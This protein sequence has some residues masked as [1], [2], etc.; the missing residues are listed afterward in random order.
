M[1]GDNVTQMQPSMTADNT[2][3]KK[4]FYDNGIEFKEVRCRFTKEYKPPTPFIRYGVNVNLQGSAGLIGKGTSYY[5][6]S[7][8]MLF[9]SKEEMAQWL[10]YIGSQHKFYDEKGTVYL[11]IVT[12]EPEIEPIQQETKYLVKISLTLVKKQD[13]ERR[14]IHGFIDIDEH[15]AKRYIEEMQS[16]GA[17][18]TYDTDGSYKQYFQ[19]EINGSRAHMVS[20]LTRTYR[21]MDRVLRGF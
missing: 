12:D 1:W 17:I 3:K 15:W 9:Y 8:Q 20:F 18:D 2:Y 5:T 19:P 7:I 13:F 11:G 10:Q 21:Y 14:K 6:S 4:L 16:I